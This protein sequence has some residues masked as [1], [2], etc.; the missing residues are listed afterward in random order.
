MRECHSPTIRNTGAHSQS[1]GDA[2]L[3]PIGS[4]GTQK[5]TRRRGDFLELE[6]GEVDVSLPLCTA[7][8]P[9]PTHLDLMRCN[10]KK[11]SLVLF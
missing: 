4:G 9:V 6:S 3:G 10:G 7:V 2:R 1:Q 11:S 5:R 8:M